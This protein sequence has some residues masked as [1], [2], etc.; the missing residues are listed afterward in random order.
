V[1]SLL[2]PHSVTLYLIICIHCWLEN[3]VFPVLYA[4]L[5][6]VHNPLILVNVTPSNSMQHSAGEV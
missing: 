5:R 4:L 3:S 1:N 2:F 6:S